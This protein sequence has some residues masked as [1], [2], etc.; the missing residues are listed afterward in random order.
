MAI[1]KKKTYN[2]GIDMS[3]EILEYI[4]T[5]ITNNIRE[6]EGALISLLA[7]STLNKKEITLDLARNMI[8]KLVKNTHKELSIDYI[9]KVVCDYFNIPI[10]VKI[11]YG[12]S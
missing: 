4:A 9:Q 8:D 11:T 3:D 5:H 6:L 1:L 10:S 7:Q 2:D 12:W